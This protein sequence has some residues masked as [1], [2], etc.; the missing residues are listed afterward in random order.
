MRKLKAIIC[1][2]NGAPYVAHVSDS[3]EALQRIV[4]GYIKTCTVT[5]DVLILCNE[6]GRLMNL[7]ENRSL[8][9]SGFCGDCLILGHKGENFTSLSPENCRFLFESCKERYMKGR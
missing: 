1:P 2:A 8:C 9:F 5:T 6:E 4:G 3:L 7:P